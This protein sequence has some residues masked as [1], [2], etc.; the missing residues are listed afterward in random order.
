MEILFRYIHEQEFLDT[1][2]NKTYWIF[3]WQTFWIHTWTR[4][5]WIH[6]LTR[7]IGFIHGPTCW[8]H[9]WTR[10]IGYTP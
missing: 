2:I 3:K 4:L 1:H 6:T 9:T 10:I 8:I 7:L 5:V